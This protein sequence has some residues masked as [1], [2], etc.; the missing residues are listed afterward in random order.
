MSTLDPMQQRDEGFTL[1]EV[2][3]TVA[4]ISIAFVAILT[5]VAGMIAAGA[6]NKHASTAEIAARNA[7]EDLKSRPYVACTL[8]PKTA[9]EGDIANS[10]MLP[11]GYTIA[12]SVRAWDGNSP[13]TF[14]GVC[15]S[16]ESGLELV[17]ITATSS[18]ELGGSFTKTL[19]V[20][21]R[22]TT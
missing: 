3:L 8:D 13:A 20:V 12:V 2:V 6:Q 17:T 15:P 10:G 22:K 9:Y 18:P 7:G 19:S 1:I 14:T 5:A 21:K 11:A 16:S 4:L